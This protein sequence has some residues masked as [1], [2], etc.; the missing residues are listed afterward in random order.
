MEI[1]LEL[2]PGLATEILI[3]KARKGELYK[4]HFTLGNIYEI[5]GRNQERGANYQR[6]RR[7]RVIDAE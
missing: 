7:G 1:Q 4:E 6:K 3:E 5:K 2:F